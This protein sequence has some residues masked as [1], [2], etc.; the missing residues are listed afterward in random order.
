[1]NG[2]VYQNNKSGGFY[3]YP[4]SKISWNKITVIGLIAS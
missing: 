2:L 4:F 1:M 3:N